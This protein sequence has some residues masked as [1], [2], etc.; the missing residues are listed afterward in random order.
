[1]L[2]SSIAV[3]VTAARVVSFLFD[4]LMWTP[5]SV[6]ET[7]SK[8]REKYGIKGVLGQVIICISSTTTSAHLSS[9]P[10]AS[11]SFIIVDANCQS[12][13]HLQGPGAFTAGGLHLFI[14]DLR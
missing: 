13:R 12:C 2:N 8:H 3:F 7:G 1:M 10:P 5:Q 4:I 14:L 6:Q 9:S 11:A